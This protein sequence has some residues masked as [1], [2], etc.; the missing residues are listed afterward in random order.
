LIEANLESSL[1]VRY[2]ELAESLNG[3]T[4]V[5]VINP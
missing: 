2:G 1:S 3:T 5:N 4:P